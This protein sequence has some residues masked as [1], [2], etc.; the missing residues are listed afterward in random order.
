MANEDIQIE[1]G[2]DMDP[3]TGRFLPGNRSKGGRPKG[4]IS[5]TERMRHRLAQL[6]PD[7]KREIIDRLIDNILQDALESE[8]NLSGKMR[9]L[10]W[11][12]IDG[13]PQQ[14]TDITSG[15][16]PIPILGNVQKHDSDEENNETPPT[17]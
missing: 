9:E 10:I 3:E 4:S 1:P 13:K 11:N 15:G 6:E 12:Y 17:D 14:H 7:T 2:R 5:L 16:K 8:S